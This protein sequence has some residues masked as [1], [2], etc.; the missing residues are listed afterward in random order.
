MKKFFLSMFCIF[1][2]T[3]C[4]VEYNLEFNDSS[5]IENIQIGPFDSSSISDFE[6]LT[7]Y[8]IIN[9]DFQEPYEMNYID[10]Y[11]NLNYEYN[12]N[13]FKMA[14]TLSSCYDLYNI[15]Y[16][17]DYYYILTSGEFKCLNYEDYT[18][19]ELIIRFK[20]NYD[21]VSSNADYVE[22]DTYVWVVNNSNSNNRA[23]DIKLDR[24]NVKEIEN[25]SNNESLTDKFLYWI[26]I[27][28]IL[29]I[30]LIIYLYVKWKGSRMNEI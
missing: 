18:I 23:I 7:P 15:S 29:L 22:D 19:D 5:F 11:L 14:E 24:N 8:A 28:I 13:N 12:V 17:D 26:V 4:S 16:D 27:G 21:I 2:L 3:G 20:S 10:N 9:N 6:Y 25:K 30:I 1:F